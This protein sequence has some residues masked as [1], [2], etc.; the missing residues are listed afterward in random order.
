MLEVII[1][2]KCG[3]TIY[4]DYIQE[5]RTVMWHNFNLIFF[6]YNHIPPYRVKNYFCEFWHYNFVLV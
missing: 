1:K 4:V 5:G 2:V 6:F 3:Q